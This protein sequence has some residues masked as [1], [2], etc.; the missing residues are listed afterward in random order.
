M[1]N[2]RPRLARPSR[3]LCVLLSISL[4]FAGPASAAVGR[5]VSGS[6]QARG[7]PVVLAP[8]GTPEALQLGASAPLASLAEPGLASDAAPLSANPAVALPASG[9]LDAPVGVPASP[10]APSVLAAAEAPRP[11]AAADGRSPSEERPAAERGESSRQALDAAAKAAEQVLSRPA[12]GEAS[13]ALAAPFTGERRR[14]GALAWVAAAAIGLGSVFLDPAA[15]GAGAPQGQLTRAE[16]AAPA[17]APVRLKASLDA[18]VYE[19]VDPVRLRLEIRNDGDRPMLV[20]IPELEAA[21]AASLG[22]DFDAVPGPAGVLIPPGQTGTVEIELQL[23]RLPAG[24]DL[25]KGGAARSSGARVSKD[26]LAFEIPAFDIPLRSSLPP[27]ARPEL[28]DI[29]AS[30]APFRFYPG[31]LAAWL[32]AA[33]AVGGGVLLWRYARRRAARI[34]DDRRPSLDPVPRVRAALAELDGRL[35]AG[36]DARS[37]Y[38]ELAILLD[39]FL[40]SAYGLHE[41]GDIPH[42]A[43]L[44][45][46]RRSLREL[47]G[48]LSA[49]QRLDEGA[50]ASLDRV[51]ESVESVL[52]VE[53]PVPVE[54]LGEDLSTARALIE[55]RIADLDAGKAQPVLT[56]FGLAQLELTWDRTDSGASRPTAHFVFPALVD[57]DVKELAAELRGAKLSYADRRTPLGAASV[58]L[59]FKGYPGQRRVEVRFPDRSAGDM[60]RDSALWISVPSLRG[61][62]LRSF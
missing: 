34:A 37:F 40:G 19:P 42:A 58:D 30:P 11:Q 21:V 3:A 26:G 32:A 1:P 16:Q 18:P 48:E 5:A 7:T 2:C 15:F 52:Y 54:R 33:S 24:V 9:V 39:Y 60:A 35:K 28:E 23:A 45:D 29:E 38:R 53:R 4:A 20:P 13:A 57:E 6:G 36:L 56:P 46:A 51:L 50:L 12:S 22:G 27:G 8:S 55:G 44:E 62:A 25:E 31:V 47:R 10:A 59:S 17:D 49:A 14:S 43:S 41:L 61:K